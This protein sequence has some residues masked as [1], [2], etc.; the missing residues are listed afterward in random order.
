M[1]AERLL[2]LALGVFLAGC[3]VE[4]YREAPP[5]PSLSMRF[6]AEGEAPIALSLPR[7]DGGDELIPLEASVLIEASH[8]DHVQL[9]ETGEG[10]RLVVIDLNDVGRERL[11]EGTTERVG[12][13]L[14]IIAGDHVIAA[15][16]IREPLTEGEAYV[17][18]PVA[19]IDAVWS[20][21]GAPSE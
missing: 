13:R 19:Q 1:L 15:P 20:A 10:E 4:T 8:I 9:Y 14:A 12:A 6:V 21:M 5:A 18:V 16:V 11:R 3:G 7:Y 2:G 17:R